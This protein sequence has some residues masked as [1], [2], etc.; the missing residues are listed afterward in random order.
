MNISLLKKKLLFMAF[1]GELTK[2]ED[3]DTN[4]N[5]YYEDFLKALSE[6]PNYEKINKTLLPINDDDIPYELSLIHI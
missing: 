1:K 3:G 5:D 2:F 6:T 4:V